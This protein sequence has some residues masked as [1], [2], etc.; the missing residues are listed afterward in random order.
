M[1]FYQAIDRYVDDMI[2]EGTFGSPRTVRTYRSTLV[3]HADDVGNRDPRYVGREDV[4]RTLARWTHPST[5]SV[6]RSKLVA[7]YDW[8]MQ[9]GYRKDNPARAT[10]PPKRRPKAKYRLSESEVLA[11][12]D[13]VRSQREARA[14]FLGVCAGLRNAELRGLQGRHFHRAGYVWVSED[15][16]KGGRERYVPVLRDLEPIVE[17]IKRNVAAE[18][19][20]LPAQRWRDPGV[21]KLPCELS[22][23]P[24]SPQALMRLVVTV[25]KRAG[26]AAHIT[27]HDMRHAYAEHVARNADTRVAQHLLGHADIGTTQIYLAKPRLDDLNAAVEHVTFGAVV[28]TSVLGVAESLRM[29]LEATTGIEPV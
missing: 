9:E 1:R 20:V 27:P 2:S 5:Q 28:R 21:N 16:A 8:F 11:L 25:S 29:G 12:L 24:S 13:A 15:I 3:V 22:L 19:Y 17:D 18:E 4:K 23:R 14:I 26:I 6:N 10:R 7:F